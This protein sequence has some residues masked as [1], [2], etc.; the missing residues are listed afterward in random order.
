MIHREGYSKNGQSLFSRD[1]RFGGFKA[2]CWLNSVFQIFEENYATTRFTALEKYLISAFHLE[3][4]KGQKIVIPGWCL[5]PRITLWSD[6]TCVI[7]DVDVCNSS[8]SWLNPYYTRY[9]DP[10]WFKR[11]PPTLFT[12]SVYDS[13]YPRYLLNSAYIRSRARAV[14]KEY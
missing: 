6:Q 13:L 11:T 8:F 1:H 4:L 12:C 3:K 14:M 5:S 10:R 7:T 2:S 9:I